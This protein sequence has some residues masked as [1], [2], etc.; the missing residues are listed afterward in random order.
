LYYIS[1]QIWAWRQNRVKKIK[2]LVDHMAVILPFEAPFYRKHRARHLCGPPLL[3]RILAMLAACHQRRISRRTG[4]WTASRIKRKRSH[5]P[6][7]RHARSGQNHKGTLPTSQFMVSCAESMNEELRQPVSSV[8][9]RQRLRLRSSK[10]QLLRYSSRAGL[11]VAASG[12]VTLEAALH[13]MPT[14]IIYKVSPLSYW[15]GKRLIKVKHIGIANLIAQ[16]ELQPELIQD[17]ASPQ[18]I[19]EQ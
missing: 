1:P 8:N 18:N 13:G 19:A 9:M 17:D 15:I 3:D 16:K 2:R 10:A 12:T 4:H 6:A 7:S 11:L 14:V 5:N